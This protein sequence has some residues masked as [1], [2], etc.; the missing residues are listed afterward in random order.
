MLYNQRLFDL[1]KED[2]DEDP[3]SKREREKAT[4]PIDLPVKNNMGYQK[5]RGLSHKAKAVQIHH[6]QEKKVYFRAEDN[7][8][9]RLKKVER[10]EKYAA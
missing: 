9:P 7:E 2:V 8:N 4:N 10:M 5:N 3:Y 1:D 6:P